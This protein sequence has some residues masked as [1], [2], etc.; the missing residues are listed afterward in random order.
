MVLVGTLGQVGGGSLLGNIAW[1]AAEGGITGGL[2]AALWSNDVGQGFL[3]G[4]KWG[5]AFA[6]GT[7]GIEA[8]GNAIGGHGFRLNE[9]VIKNYAKNGQYQD[10]I[11]FVQNKF[12]LN[13]VTFK[14]DPTLTGSYGV[15]PPVG[16]NL[17]DIGPA[18]F[19]SPDLL[20]ATMVHEYGH[21]I[22]GQNKNCLWRFL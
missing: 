19:S 20:K 17:V 11:D 16:A 3:N 2:D 6:A 5:A 12:G 4:A 15:T 9:G 13:G 21:A 22:F 7:S 14:Y 18:A 8:T 1:G 10:A